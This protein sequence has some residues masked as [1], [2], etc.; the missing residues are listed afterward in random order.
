[1]KDGNRGSI[2]L[3]ISIFMHILQPGTLFLHLYSPNRPFATTLS[4]VHQWLAPA[5]VRTGQL[6]Q[7]ALLAPDSW[8]STEP[9]I[10]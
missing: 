3:P 10:S 6:L 8:L 5:V 4:D 2:V 9:A 7:T 1:M